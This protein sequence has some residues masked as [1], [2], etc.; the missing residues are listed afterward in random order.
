MKRSRL[1]L[2]LLATLAIAVIALIAGSRLFGRHNLVPG[3]QVSG[4]FPSGEATAPNR[5]YSVYFTDPGGAQASTFR[6]GPD[7]SLAE[8]IHQAR[9]S[10]DLA[11]YELDLWSVRDALKDAHRNGVVVRVVTDSDQLEGPEFQALVEGGIPVRGDSQESLMHD[12]F[13]IIDRMEVWTGSMNLTLSSAYES[14]NNLLRI[15]SPELAGNYL[16]EFEEM[17]TQ[18]CFGSDSPANTPYPVVSVGSTRIET[19]FSPE[20]GTGERLVALIR[21]ARQSV[22]FLAYSFTSDEIAEA[23]LERARVGVPVVGVMDESQAK[24]NSGA[25]YDRLRDQGLDVYMDGNPENMHHKVFL[26]D[27]KV[28]VT[29]SYNFSASAEERNDENTLILHDRQIAALYRAE[30]E[31]VLAEAQR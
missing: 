19:Y 8:A 22:Y 15:R 17:F 5:W 30:F 12:K 26:I 23:L 13:A 10:V 28:V 24:T 18:G 14:D 9:L 31:R 4:P 16:A 7:A 3:G 6:G 11:V 20:D 1:F 29:G 2:A 25:E 21:G 27:E